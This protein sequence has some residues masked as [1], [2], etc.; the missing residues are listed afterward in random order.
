ML[1]ALPNIQRTA[2]RATRPQKLTHHN[3]TGKQ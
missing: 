1:A 2:Q 3:R